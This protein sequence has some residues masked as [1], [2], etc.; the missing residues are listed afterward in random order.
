M[1]LIG[2]SGG[3]EPS[4]VGEALAAEGIA[5]LSAAYFA[6]PRLPVELRG[7]DLEYFFSAVELLKAELR[8]LAVPIAVLGMSR[9]SEAAILTATYL[10]SLVRGVVVTVPG[11][12]VA[13]SWPPGGPAWLLDNRPLPYVDHSGPGSEDPDAFLPVELVQGPVPADISRCRPSLA[14]GCDGKSAF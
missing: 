11:N 3:S 13:G 1:L 9:G 5:A 2:G 10:G 6:R 12:V 8:S 7:I 14:V 4:Y